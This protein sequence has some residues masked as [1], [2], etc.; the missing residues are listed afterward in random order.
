MEYNKSKIISSDLLVF[1]INNLIM[2]ISSKKLIIVHY[3]HFLVSNIKLELFK[4]KNEI[5]QYIKIVK[6]INASNMRIYFYNLR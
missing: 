2:N 4:N 5:Y 6:S 1:T 3:V